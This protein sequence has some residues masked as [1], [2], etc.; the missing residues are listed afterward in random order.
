[1]PHRIAFTVLLGTAL[2]SLP[3]AAQSDPRRTASPRQHTVFGHNDSRLTRSR[4]AQAFLACRTALQDE[5][6]IQDERVRS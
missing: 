1:M 3:A 5:R 2:A 4:Q 6:V